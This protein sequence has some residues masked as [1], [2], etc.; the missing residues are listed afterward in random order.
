MMPMA[1]LA[2]RSAWHRRL[3][4]SL[5][6]ASMALSAFL[7][8][9][10]ERVRADLRDGFAQSVSGTDLVVGPR[11]SGLQLLLQSVF[12]V[13]A[14]T[15]AIRWRSAE[16]VAAHPAVAWTIPLAF[17]DTVQGFPV[18]ATTPAFLERF[19]HGDRRA[20]ALAQG[21]WFDGGHGA[22]L[23]ADVARQLS[24]AVGGTLTLAHGDG[25]LAENDHDDEPF[26]VSGVL[27]RTG[28]PVDRAVYVPLAAMQSLHRPKLGGI[29]LPVM[30][31]LD[32]AA[33]EGPPLNAVLVGLR[34]RA[35]VFA[36]QRDVSEMRTEPLMAVLP[37]VAL[38][39]LWQ[40]VGAGE[41]ALQA[42]SALVAVVSVAGLMA[43][44]LAGLEP[45]RRELAI[46]RAV[47]ARPS[48]IVGLL[49]A[50]GALLTLAAM[51]IGLAAHFAAVAA[52]A[53]PLRLRTGLSLTL[54]WPGAEA[55][56]TMAAILFGGVVASLVPALRACRLSLADG[57]VPKI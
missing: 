55:W 27:E 44:I 8:L 15:N 43:V 24:L 14:A 31:R 42:A 49:L 38:D 34:Q 36:V 7:L 57:L 56:L 26:T 33:P 52:L 6:A 1:M 37:G 32:G 30:P 12:H 48:Q 4:L 28:T 13:G 51:A 19:R 53:E 45:R 18:V 10:L 20:L 17:G 5:V 47:G 40:V 50:E 11:G 41:R 9:T 16:A 22:V 39:E 25:A 54:A 23:G 46:L 2:I 35:A 3:V 29:E 21:R